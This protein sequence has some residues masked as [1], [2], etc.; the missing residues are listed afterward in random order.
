MYFKD[1]VEALGHTPLVEMSHLSPNKKVR[2]LAKMEGQSV[3]GSGSI[4][5]RVARYMIEAAEAGGSLA[6]RGQSSKPPVVIP[7]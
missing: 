7:G 2:I 5:D 6:G 4:K 1:N 3:G